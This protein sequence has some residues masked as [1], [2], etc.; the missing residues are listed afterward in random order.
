MYP[1][2]ATR[3]LA[4]AIY[5]VA[6]LPSGHHGGTSSGSGRPSVL[7][8]T[9]IMKASTP[10]WYGWADSAYM[11]QL[12][13]GTPGFEVDFLDSQDD[14]NRSRLFRYHAVV[15]FLSPNAPPLLRPSPPSL[16]LLTPLLFL[17]SFLPF[18]P[19]RFSRGKFKCALDTREKRVY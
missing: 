14:L 9:P 12:Y 6:T 3:A 2:T 19:H 13:N 17:P 15:L 5:A 1:C 16:P 18:S 8:A 7:F 10:G 11:Q 4:V